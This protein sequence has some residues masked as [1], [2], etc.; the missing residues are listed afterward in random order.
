MFDELKSFIERNFH[1]ILTT[2]DPADADGLGAEIVF[3]R[4]LQQMKKQFRIINGSPIPASFKFMDKFNLIETWDKDKHD[5]LP[6]I[7]AILMLDTAD[8]HHTG[9]M[10]EVICR[11]ADVFVFD[12]HESNANVSFSGICDS[13]AASTSELAVEFAEEAGIELDT[14]TA[15]AAYAGIAYDTGFF[16]YQ[17]TGRRTLK[18]AL[19]LL[20]VG[21]N[22]GG[23][24]KWL[25]ENAS[26]EALML[27]KKAIASLKLHFNNRVAVQVLRSND[28]TEVGASSEDTEGLVNIPMR[29]KDILISLLI[30]EMPDGKIRC[31]LRSKDNVNV[32]KIAHDFGGGGHINAAGFK[33]DLTVEK[34]IEITMLIISRHL[35]L[36]LEQD[37]S[38]EGDG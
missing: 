3:A 2:H 22:P 38:L 26:I 34:I 16:A 6:E 5:S 33:S 8:L 31:S 29:A 36:P 35:N 18:A 19:S 4:I 30:K 12:H 1:I 17:K 37:T 13:K 24:Y 9:H 14:Q 15:Y 28:F 20:D 32:S 11:A 21:V 7:S 10:R 25:H 27:Q 23:V